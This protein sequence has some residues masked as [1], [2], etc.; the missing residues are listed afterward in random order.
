MTARNEG[1]SAAVSG[2]IRE[3]V[4]SRAFDAP[5]DLM[6]KVWTEPDRLAKWFGPKG[7]KIFHSKNDLRPGGIYHYA[8][9]TPDDKEMWGKWV[10]REIA[11]PERLVFV[12]SFSDP[13][14]NVTRHP[15]ML[16]WP[17]EMLTTVTFTEREGK[18]T[19]TVQWLPISPT[20][21]ERQTFEAGREGMK[22]GWSGTFDQLADYLAKEKKQ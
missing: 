19:V 1:S 6:W 16:D 4:I 12:N 2:Q 22:A 9:R 13:E 18:T 5:R 8:M 7:V 15:L 17:R 21:A 11:K 3:F 10:Y 20:E 14:G